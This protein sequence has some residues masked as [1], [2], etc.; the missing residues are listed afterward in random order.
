MIAIDVHIIIYGIAFMLFYDTLQYIIVCL[1]LDSE[2]LCE[3]LNSVSSPQSSL[4]DE[5]IQVVEVLVAS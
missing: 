2:C 3:C 4:A 5:P 1:I